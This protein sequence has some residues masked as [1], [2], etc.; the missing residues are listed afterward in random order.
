[1]KNKAR[2]DYLN[3]T[4][5]QAFTGRNLTCFSPTVIYKRASETVVGTGISRCV[6]LSRQIKEY[7][8]NLK[9]YIRGED[10]K[11]PDSLHLINP[12]LSTARS[13]RAISHNPVDFSTVPKFQERDL[14]LGQSLKLAIW[15]IGVLALFN[16]VFFAASFVSFMRY[17]PR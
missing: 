17:D 8:A 7:Q 12:E 14:A 10:A 15:D 11:D 16:L 3:K 5:A 6:D 9:E 4:L 13:W 2:E 1:M